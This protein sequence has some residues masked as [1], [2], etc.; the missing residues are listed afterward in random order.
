M[1]RGSDDRTVFLLYIEPSASDKADSPI[2]D[3]LVEVLSMALEKATRGVANYSHVDEE[4]RFR[5]DLCYKGFHRTECGKISDNCD[6]LLENGMITNSLAPYY[7]Q[8]Y[9]H[10]IPQS[11]MI[12]IQQL[13]EFYQASLPE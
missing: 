3:R 7:M 2:N 4:P 11:E 5:E 1:N 8:Y 13:V 12:K 6:H 9:R 10:V